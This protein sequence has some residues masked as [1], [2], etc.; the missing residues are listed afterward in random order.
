MGVS[1]ITRARGEFFLR[2]S[3]DAEFCEIIDHVGGILVG[4]LQNR[5]T[6]LI[7]GNGGSSSQSQHMAGEIVGRFLKER[8]GLPAIALSADT[9][10]ITAVAND[11]G[12]EKVFSRQ[13]EAYG[14]SNSALVGLSTSGNSANVIQAMAKAKELGVRT[15]GLL[16]KNGGRLQEMCDHVILVPS[17]DTQE[18]QEMHLHVIHLLCGIIDEQVG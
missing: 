14:G 7:C 17:D 6:I 10:T 11:Y 9:A 16:G 5:G 13:V 2:I 3:H 4:V 8:P 18:I 1:E 12:Y 15:V